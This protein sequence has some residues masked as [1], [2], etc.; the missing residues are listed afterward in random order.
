MNLFIRLIADRS[1]IRHIVIVYCTMVNIVCSHIDSIRS[2]CH[3]NIHLIVWYDCLVHGVVSYLV[4]IVHC[5]HMIRGNC[6]YCCWRTTV[7][8]NSQC[9]TRSGFIEY[10]SLG[11]M[12]VPLVRVDERCLTTMRNDNICYLGW[13]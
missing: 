13:L 11:P 2:D 12:L 7:D 8:L 10:F 5:I 9:T 6:T 3:V 1:V 4:Y